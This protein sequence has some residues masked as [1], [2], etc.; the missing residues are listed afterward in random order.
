MPAFH[1]EPDPGRN[2]QTPAHD[3]RGA[4]GY[5]A[6]SLRLLADTGLGLWMLLGAA[7]ALGIF[8][9]GRGESLVPL[10][11]G[12]LFLGAGLLVACFRGPNVPAWHG[13]HPRRRG[14]PTG[15]ALIALAT[16]LLMLA[17]AGLTRGDNTFWPTRIAGAVLALCS[18]GSLIQGAHD[19]GK[20]SASLPIERV[21]FACYA[22]GLW[23]R[24]CAVADDPAVLGPASQLWTLLLLILALLLG[25]AEGLRWRG[26]RKNSPALP[27]GRAAAHGSLRYVAALLSYGVPCVTLLL[28]E[29][30]RLGLVLVGLAACCCL[31]GK[32]L[33]QRLHR[34]A[35]DGEADTARF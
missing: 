11:L 5:A 22:G 8:R 14:W 35:P 4:L 23:L 6:I 19:R 33:E 9:A 15:D 18:L 25:L 2:E 7:L 26:Q 21:L 13:W 24:L 31:L 27:E 16:F 20:A 34:F 30:A 12:A 29:P 32:I 1:N 28:A 10:A 3:Q 17:V